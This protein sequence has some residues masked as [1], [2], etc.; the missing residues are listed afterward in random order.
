VVTELTSEAE[1]DYKEDII[2]IDAL[3]VDF[4]DFVKFY[5]TDKGFN[6]NPPKIFMR[7]N[8]KKTTFVYKS[9][10]F[11]YKTTITNE[12]LNQKRALLM[13]LSNNVFQL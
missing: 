11:V 6:N 5:A 7:S 1:S 3:K 2:G 12:V 10:D 8:D 9:S 13:N 4:K